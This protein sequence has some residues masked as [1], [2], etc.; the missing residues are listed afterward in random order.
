M[1]KQENEKQIL[2]K[3]EMEKHLL[4]WARFLYSVYKN[5]KDVVKEVLKD[6]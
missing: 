5:N 4:E 6:D 1:S 2:S 3:E